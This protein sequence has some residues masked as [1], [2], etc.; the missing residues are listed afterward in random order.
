MRL[1]FKHIFRGMRKRPLQPL[2]LVF[3]IMLSVSISILAIGIKDA[4]ARE[5]DEKH[6]ARYGSADITVSLNG[7]SASRFMFSSDAKAL[8]PEGTSV[9][10]S[11]ELPMFLGE[12][13]RVAFGGTFCGRGND[14]YRAYEIP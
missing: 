4:F 11:Y 12:E 3:T 13:K 14:G 2:I 8:M 1:F 5:T 10:G 7:L 6:E 9:A